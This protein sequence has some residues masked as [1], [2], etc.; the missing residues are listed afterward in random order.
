[1][2][3]S[4]EFPLDAERIRELLPHRYPMLLVDRVWEIGASS[5]VAEKQVSMN[6]PFLAGHFPGQ[7][8]MP[9]VLIIEAIAQAAGLQVLWNEPE[10]RGR[11]IALLA[12]ERSRFRRPV[13]PG[14]TMRLIADRVR[15]RGEIYVFEGQ[16]QVK[17]ELAA[18]TRIKAAFVNWG[19]KT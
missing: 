14:E 18:E 2:A 8:I 9:G 16:A 17:G 19:E 5:V 13:V 6:D 7:P 11:G 12:L 3:E 15:Q 10:N 1:M 4:D